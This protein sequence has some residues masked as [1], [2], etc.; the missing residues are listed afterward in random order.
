VNAFDLIAVEDLSVN[1]MTHS[2]CLAKSI[3]DVAWSQ[4]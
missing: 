1:R 3:H 4:T 2:H